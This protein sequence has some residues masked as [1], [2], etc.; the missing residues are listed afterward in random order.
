MKEQLRELAT[1][2]DEIYKILDRKIVV[3]LGEISR[4]QRRHPESLSPSNS[5]VV[6]HEPKVVNLEAKVA[7]L[8]EEN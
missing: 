3:L 8:E 7:S 2:V 4:E 5:T 6:K 1:N